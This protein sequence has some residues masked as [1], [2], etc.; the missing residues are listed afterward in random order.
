MMDDSELKLMC[1]MST[2]TDK[3]LKTYIKS[4]IKH[5]KDSAMISIMIEKFTIDVKE[6]LEE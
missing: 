5:M 3:L 2:D 4:E 1:K 6:E